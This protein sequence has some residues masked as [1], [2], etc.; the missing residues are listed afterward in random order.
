MLFIVWSPLRLAACAFCRPNK[1]STTVPAAL[2]PCG[3]NS[4]NNGAITIGASS[5]SSSSSSKTSN[6]CMR[7]RTSNI[8]INITSV[9]C[10]SITSNIQNKYNIFLPAG[11]LPPGRA[12][13]SCMCFV[14]VRCNAQAYIR[15]NYPS[16]TPTENLH[17]LDSSI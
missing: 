10:M 13:T 15:C 2:L 9:I 5:S 7:V 12:Q 14:Y 8:C 1:G 3:N 16:K 11:G 4:Q 17:D 6:M